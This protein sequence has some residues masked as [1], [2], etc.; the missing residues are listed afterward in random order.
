MNNNILITS[1]GLPS[2][3]IGSWNIMLSKLIDAKPFLFTHII[4]PKS[5]SDQS[6]SKYH[7]VQPYKIKSYKFQKIVKHYRYKNYYKVLKKILQN[8]Q[9]V[10]VN[11]I[12]NINMLLSIHQLLKKDNLRKKVVLIYHLHGFDLSINDKS[13]FYKSAD[14]LFVLTNTTHQILEK[15]KQNLPCRIKQIYNGI[16]TDLFRPVPK[17]QQQIIK[18][19]LNF[20][21][22]ITYYL[23]VSQDRKKKG[24]HV[25]LEAW[26]L[27]VEDKPNV[28]LL[29]IGTEKD[30]YNKKQV[31][32][33]GRIL[34]HQ[35]PR[36]YQIATF[37]LFSTLCHEG[38]PLA[39]TEALVSG[40]YCL[41]S[42][43]E[44]I[45]EV[46][47]NGEYGVLVEY[48]DNSKSWVKSL[49]EALVNYEKEGNQFKLPNKKYSLK[50]WFNNME[51]LIQEEHKHKSN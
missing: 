48:P 25:I 5:D 43:I 39:L 6:Y 8:E 10:T 17:S 16:D 40:C 7:I 22:N 14:K 26:E 41:A 35:L 37:F 29:V 11:I 12:D 18:E 28:R 9:Y 38:H 24:L 32:F 1:I 50:N 31:V 27:F 2:T 20:E 45:P 21:D 23:W 47:N 36:Y 44:P 15:E 19:E 51:N 46:L 3:E 34:N 33:L 4:C 30:K 13:L 49:N 42:H